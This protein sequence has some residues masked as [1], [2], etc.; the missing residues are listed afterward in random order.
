M[1]S[2]H[3]MLVLLR[4]ALPTGDRP[5]KFYGGEEHQVVGEYTEP[6]LPLPGCIG[7]PAERTPEPPLV[8]A[9]GG[10]GLPPL[11]VHPAVPAALGLLAEPLDHLPPVPGLRP[12]PA[13]PAAV[14]RDDGGTDPEFL[15]AVPVVGLRI[16]RGVGQHPVPRHHQRRPG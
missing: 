14:D 10:L 5:A 3:A 6:A 12:L 16:E 15:P 9:E 4:H 13:P 1:S 2:P 7:P 11:A 8:P